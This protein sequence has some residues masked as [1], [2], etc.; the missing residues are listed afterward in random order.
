MND[1][2]N[3]LTQDL[4]SPGHTETPP[5]GRANLGLIGLI[6]LL[7]LVLMFVTSVVCIAVVIA[8]HWVTTTRRADLNRSLTDR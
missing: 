4:D 5:S 7:P 1:E 6:F 2:T 3:D 8:R